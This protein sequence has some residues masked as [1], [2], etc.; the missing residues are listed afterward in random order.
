MALA[1][2]LLSGAGLLIRSLHALVTDETGFDSRHVLTFSLTSGLLRRPQDVAERQ[3]MDLRRDASTRRIL[4]EIQ[5]LPGVE[6][7]AVAFPLPFGRGF[8]GDRFEVEGRPIPPGAS[9]PEAL[10]RQVSP[11]YGRALGMRLVRGRWFT[12]T[13]DEFVGVVNETMARGWWRGEDA[14]G[15][16]L[17]LGT[18]AD[19]SPWYTVLAVAVRGLAHRPAHLRERCRIARVRRPGGVRG[20]GLA[21]HPSQPSRRA[22]LRVAPARLN[23]F[24]QRFDSS[25]V[26]RHTHRVSVSSTHDKALRINI[27]A[28]RYGTFAE[29]GAGQEVARWFFHVGGAAGTVAKTMSAYDMTVSDAVYG[30]IKRYV[31][32]QRLQSMLDHEWDLLLERLDATRGASTQFF[33]FADT[34]AAKSFSRNEEGHGWLGIRFQAAPRAAASEIILHARMW[35]LENARQQAALGVLGVNLLHA[36]FYDHECPEALIGSLMDGLTRDRMEVDMIKL[37]GPAFEGVDNRLMSLQLVEQRLTHAVL[38]SPNGEV[39]EPA[40]LLYH[41]PVL[42]ERGSFRP[43]TK[44]TQE[45]LTRALERMRGESDMRGREPVVLMEMTLRNLQSLGEK[46][47]HADFLERVDVLRV[48]GRTVMVTNYSRFHNVTTYL[49]RYTPERIGMVVGIP[50]L[51]QILD[52][53][54]YGDLEGGVLEALGRLLAGPVTLY[55][56]P[57]RHTATGEIVTAENFAVPAKRAHLYAY[58]RENLFVESIEAPADPDLSVMPHDVLALIQAHDPA[59]EGLVPPEVVGVIKGSRLFGYAPEALADSAPNPGEQLD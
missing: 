42:L 40:E 28:A 49:R 18:S 14:V 6:A 25:R 29:I 38:F 20:P 55:V 4:D 47:A 11:G 52:E 16:R 51:A 41:A 23:L 58:L 10:V 9:S 15:K 54:H 19:P 27:D 33:V 44:V 59:W 17:R 53:K 7:A 34:V 1:L 3:A 30:P 50:T 13:D 36:A 31:S 37:A 21:R 5:T 8:S 43:V 2:V 56:Y 35:D 32:R 24:P 45:M 48:L 12:A 57:W 39:L 22:A 26:Q 46:V